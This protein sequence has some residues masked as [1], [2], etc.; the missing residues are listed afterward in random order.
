MVLI[1]GYYS[2]V[3]STRSALQYR[4]EA[5]IFNSHFRHSANFAAEIGVGGIVLF[6]NWL[7]AVSKVIYFLIFLPHEIPTLCSQ[8]SMKPSFV[9]KAKKKTS[10][11]G[12]YRFASLN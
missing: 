2:S 1:P 4:C 8:F 6:V 12:A 11:R 3:K 10:H 9:P 7:E 5:S